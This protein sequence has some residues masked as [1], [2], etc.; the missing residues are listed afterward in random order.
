[1]TEDRPKKIKFYVCSGSRNYVF[2]EEQ[3]ENRLGENCLEGVVRSTTFICF[4]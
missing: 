2:F 3:E 4:C 1:M